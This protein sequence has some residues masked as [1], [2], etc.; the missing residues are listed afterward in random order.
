[1]KNAD[2]NADL[3]EV[4]GT[5]AVIRGQGNARAVQVPSMQGRNG[6]NE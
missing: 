6:C 1:M 5:D 2:N 4:Q 3:Q